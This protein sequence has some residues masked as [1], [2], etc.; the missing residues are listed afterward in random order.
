MSFM[1]VYKLALIGCLIWLTASLQAQV[2][3]NKEVGKKNEQLIDSLKVS[4]YPYVL[5]IL[6]AKATKAGYNLPYSAGISTQ[7]FTQESSIIIENLQVGFNNGTMYN[8]DEIVRFDDAIAKASAATIRPDIWLLP[9]LNVYGIFGRAAAST[10]VNFGIWL[11]DSTNTAKEILSTSTV[12]EFQTS[13]FGLGITPTL[14]VGGGFMALDMNVSWTDVPQLKKPAQTFIFGP[15]FGK[16]FRFKRPDQGIAVWA[17][18]FRV[19]LNS[20][21]VGSLPLADILPPDFGSKVDQGLVRVDESQQE[22]DTWWAGLSSTEQRNPVNVA[23]YETANEALAKAG[24]ILYAAEG[25][26]NTI[27]NS[28]VQY[29]MDKRPKDMWNFIVGTQYQ[30]NKHFMIRGEVG[31]LGS[32]TQLMVG[33]QYRFGL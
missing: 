31:F 17:G 2:F 33:L 3:T 15:R 8:L 5:P 25:A 32:R 26:I 7:Y 30:H 28:T 14:G 24:E 20:V 23:K 12:I 29:S 10:E 27:E 11:P 16:N 6:G 21:T 19:K 4:E 13:T 18:G 1:S 22:V 9:F